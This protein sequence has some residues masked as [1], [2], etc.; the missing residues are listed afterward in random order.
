MT[1][2]IASREIGRNFEKLVDSLAEPDD[3][4]IVERD[5]QPVAVVMSFAAYE[6]LLHEEANRDWAIIDRLR[7][8]NADKD[9]DEVFADVTAE[10]AALRRERREAQ[11]PGA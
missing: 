7:E 8:R 11:R 2:A 5:G 10:I 3:E 4:V 9:P 1:T 6:R